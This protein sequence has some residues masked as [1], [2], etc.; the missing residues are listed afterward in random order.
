MRPPHV[1]LP[2]GAFESELMGANCNRV[3][4]ALQARALRHPK[5]VKATC[6]GGCAGPQWLW[7]ERIWTRPNPGH[8][9]PRLKWCQSCESDQQWQLV[10][11][12]EILAQFSE[13]ELAAANVRR[14]QLALE[15]RRQA[16]QSPG[17][18]Q[19][20]RSI[21]PGPG[22]WGH[23]SKQQAP[24]PGTPETDHGQPLPQ[25]QGQ[26]AAIPQGWVRQE[27]SR[28]PGLLYYR[29]LTS[30]RTQFELPME[31]PRP[32]P[33]PMMISNTGSSTSSGSAPGMM[34][35]QRSTVIQTSM[36]PEDMAEFTRWRQQQQRWHQYS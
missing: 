2:Q 25:R 28:T 10:L 11:P 15:D 19:P 36:N 18:P 33:P 34:M 17:V 24:A 20:T 5:T 26:P 21:S 22:P 35:S 6:R 3:F 31:E 29:H 30:N 7:V 1:L 9:N 12:Q 16:A 27:S 23:R 32:P 8:R 13:A 4:E 14:P